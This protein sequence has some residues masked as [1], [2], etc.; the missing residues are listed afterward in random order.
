MKRLLIGVIKI[1]QK[2]PGPWHNMCRHNPSCSN[3]AID[4]IDEFG[5]F[6]GGYL[7][8]KRILRCNPWGS[9][10]YDPLIKEEKK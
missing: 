1:Y 6:K 3:Y 7:A 2:I 4:A 8:F 10:G 5:A 9:D